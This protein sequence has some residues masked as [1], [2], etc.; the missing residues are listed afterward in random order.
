MLRA[1][2]AE[3]GRMPDMSRM[4]RK[5]GGRFFRIFIALFVFFG[6]L[7]TV[8]WLGFFLTKGR[9]QGGG[10][11]LNIDIPQEINNFDEITIA[12]RYQNRET[13]PLAATSL[14]LRYPQEIHITNV[15]PKADNES[16][17]RWAL[18]TLGSGEEKVITLKG[19]ILGTIGKKLSAQAVFDYRP[20][21]FNS[22]FQTV[23]TVEFSI[24]DSPLSISSAAPEE[25]ISG[26]LVNFET[27][28][29]NT[30]EE[31]LNDVRL[32][33]DIPES[34]V[35]GTSEPKLDD[36]NGILIKSLKP[37]EKSKIKLSGA[38]TPE[39]EGAYTLIARAV[40]TTGEREATLKESASIITVKRNNF[41]ARLFVNERAE[42]QQI[43]PGDTLQVR[44]DISNQTGSDVEG[45]RL[46]VLSSSP[47]IDWS[48]VAAN[49]KGKASDDGLA[50]DPK[51]FSKL[52]KIKHG[53]TASIS[54]SLPLLA[55]SASGES[56]IRL[57]AIAEASKIGGR[58]VEDET[59]SQEIRLR[60]GSDL[61][62][63]A[64][65]RYYAD[66]KTTLGSGPLPPEVGKETSY[67]II[68]R[69]SNT[70]HKLENIKAS[71]ILPS[72]VRFAGKISSDSGTLAFDPSTRIATWLLDQVPADAKPLEAQ[73]DVILV[74]DEIDRGK[75]SLLLGE[76]E[77]EAKDTTL[78]T[79][80]AARGE[81]LTT[82]LNGDSIAEGKGIVK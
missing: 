23:K 57:T 70:L 63:S 42:D 19:K 54:F 56:L 3:G 44:A 60:V 75:L 12:I 26:E 32:V 4:E 76:T 14:D 5:K 36:Q 34:L 52:T 7:A 50:W 49:P 10:V 61:K 55:S 13:S 30:G 15:E 18:G 65:A 2:W 37:G 9:V 48:K 82:N 8:S 33:L 29:E 16:S 43:K 69:L 39:A 40:K 28:M 6:L 1:I 22:D 24:Q 72:N 66:K 31:V 79:G 74:P 41:I 59:R 46:S 17:T 62:V 51:S 58:A 80:I 25:I 11:V 67:R 78:G 64:R 35:L 38:F 21:N 53:E 77:V 47:L 73:F 81:S 45:V 68:W 71:A 20:S 27:A